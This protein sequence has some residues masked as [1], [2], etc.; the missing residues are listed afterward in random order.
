MPGC[1]VDE[2]ASIAQAQNPSV[3][4][5]LCQLALATLK[6]TQAMVVKYLAGSADG[7]GR[8]YARQ[9]SAQQLPRSVPLVYG[10]THKEVGMSGAH[11]EILRRLVGSNT[12]YLLSMT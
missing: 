6:C 7:K 1:T 4:R 11:Y 9:V 2:L 3:R 5:K 10:N 12:L 8:V